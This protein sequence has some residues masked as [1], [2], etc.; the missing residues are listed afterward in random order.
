MT[1][2]TA[3]EAVGGNAVNK[4]ADVNVNSESTTAQESSIK[5]TPEE[6]TNQ[7]PSDQSQS[8]ASSKNENL[9]PLP[10]LPSSSSSEDMYDLFAP[11]VSK[12]VRRTRPNMTVVTAADSVLTGGEDDG[13]VLPP[14]RQVSY[15][16][17]VR[18]GLSSRLEICG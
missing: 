8:A 2:P 16:G 10:N 18:C 14:F 6:T 15:F 11:P 7:S 13:V 1:P 12:N 4:Q 17:L 9:K 5:I 3:D